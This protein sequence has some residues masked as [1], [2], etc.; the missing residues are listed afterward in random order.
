VTNRVYLISK[1][2]WIYGDEIFYEDQK[3]KDH[4]SDNQT[5]K[6]TMQMDI[7]WSLYCFEFMDKI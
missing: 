4:L 1:V 2:I 7:I 3:T 5:S 6:E